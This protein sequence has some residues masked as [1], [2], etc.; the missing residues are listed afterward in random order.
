[1]IRAMA[2]TDA[3]IPGTTK[4]RRF[5]PKFHYELLVCGL[6]GHELIGTDAAELRPEDA[7]VAREGEGGLRWHRCLRCDSWLPLRRPSAPTRRYPP[8]RE[9]TEVPLRGRALRDKVVL[10]II[11]L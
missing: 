5:V 1:M 3:A 4:P 11:A 6:A 2:K 8:R 10:R 9:E 7:A